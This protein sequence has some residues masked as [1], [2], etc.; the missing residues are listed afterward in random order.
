MTAPSHAYERLAEHGALDQLFGRLGDVANGKVEL[1][2]GHQTRSFPGIRR[3]KQYLQV[4]GLG[5]QRGHQRREKDELD[6]IGADEGERPLT[7]FWH[8]LC[9]QAEKRAR[10]RPR[11]RNNAF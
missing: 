10:M 3:P 7:C 11:L 1:S 2:T 6:E 4:R 5:G 8:E 9:R